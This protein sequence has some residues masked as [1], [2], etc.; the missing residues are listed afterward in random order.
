LDPVLRHEPFGALVAED[1]VLAPGFADVATI[2]RE[3][4]EWLS[5]DGLLICEHGNM[6]RE[7]SLH[8]AHEARFTHVR[9]LDDLYGN[10]RFLVA[11]R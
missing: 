1:T 6:Q 9:D 3:S 10:P 4:S 5:R 2:I 11:R 8:A 7:A